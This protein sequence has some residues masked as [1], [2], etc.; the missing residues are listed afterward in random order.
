[1]GNPAVPL[2]IGQAGAGRPDSRGGDE[3]GPVGGVARDGADQAGAADAM[4]GDG[5]AHGG[6][7]ERVREVVHRRPN[8]AP[9]GRGTRGTAPP[10]VGGGDR[11]GIPEPY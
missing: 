6:A 1:M 5:P 2:E 11:T 10:P 3:L 4:A 7:D 9:P 8:I